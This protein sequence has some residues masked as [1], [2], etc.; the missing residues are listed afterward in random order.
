MR[1]TTTKAP[2]IQK[3]GLVKMRVAKPPDEEDDVDVLRM[4]PV[5]MEP[6]PPRMLPKSPLPLPMNEVNKLIYY[7][8]TLLRLLKEPRPHALRAEATYGAEAKEPPH[9]RPKLPASS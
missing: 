2:A 8:I 5:P 4:P 3:A 7:S 1:T 9:H 6:T